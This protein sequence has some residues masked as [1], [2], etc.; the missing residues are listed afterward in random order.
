M[1]RPA[2]PVALLAVLLALVAGCGGGDAGPP[3]AVTGEPV[4]VR[5]LARAAST[6]AEASSGRFSFGLEAAMPGADE[7]FSFSGEGAFDLASERA[8]FSVDMSS[9]A[10]LLGG[11]L[12]G[13]GAAAGADAPDFDDAEGWRIDAVRDGSTTY[14]RFPALAGRLPEGKA[15]IR[16][17]DGAAASGLDGLGRLTE[18]EPRELLKIIRE[19]SGDVETVGSET[20]RG[21]ETTHYRATLDGTR[22]PD[23]V[24]Q[25]G[26]EDVRALADQLLSQAGLSEI[27]LDVWI[28]ADGLLRKFQ[29]DVSA[30]QAGASEPSRAALTFEI[31]DV[32]RPV[33]IE[34]PPASEVVDAGLED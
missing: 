1:A 20:V 23:S 15:W 32:G 4:D 30:T 24:P 27:P 33:A 29:L 14:V 16:S 26:G 8:S 2:V 22:V 5:Q 11:L 6:S 7:P 10:A 21:A 12:T 28:D 3:S 31:W 13:L 34:L 9:F 19:V 25:A 18:V 17:E